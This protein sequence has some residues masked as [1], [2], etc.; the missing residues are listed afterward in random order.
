[1]GCASVQAQESLTLDQA[2]RVAL[3]N[4]YSIKISRNNQNI[5]ERNAKGAVSNLLP[6]VS[7]DFVANKSV[8]NTDLTLQSGA[9]QSVNGAEN[10]NMNYGIGLDWKIFD[11][12][13]M[14]VNYDR[15]KEF[16]KLGDVNAK[17]LVQST[18]ANVIS[19][20]YDLVKQKQELEASKD[21]LEISQIRLR[22]ADNRYKIGRG[23]KLEVL[24]ARV[25]L[26]TDTT[27]L[28][29]QLDSYKN[30]AISLNEIL[31]RD[32]HTS[33]EVSD[34]ILIDQGLLLEN[35]RSSV[36]SQNPELLSAIINQQLSTLNLRAVRANRYPDISLNTGYNFAKSTSA[37]GFARE[38]NAQGFNY[39]ITASIPLFNG[40]YQ[41]RSEKNAR[42]EL[43]SAE[44]ELERTQLNIQARLQINYQNYLTSLELIKLEEANL[45]VAKQNMDISLEKYK[46]GS[47]V[48]LELREAQRNYI[49]ANTRYV[50]S[51]YTAKISEINLKQLAGSLIAF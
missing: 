20:Y 50:N 48:P 3:E 17:L 14:F 49:D 36:Q 18:V 44:Y 30:T 29:R 31:A 38:L 39:G 33:F 15:L 40:F 28:L 12:F 4:N 25:D 35:L 41:N 37:T 11:G 21:A 23:S 19:T 47:I 34:S 9:T 24:A 42:I 51:L 32:I 26:N 46:L 27:T 7:G 2:I 6:V 16:Q 5:A 43:K 45:D 8:Q 1:M 13:E 10:T 22:D